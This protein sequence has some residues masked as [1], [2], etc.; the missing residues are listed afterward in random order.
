MFLDWMTMPP[1]TH[2][3]GV[4]YLFL[5][6]LAFLWG[7]SYLFLKIAVE[8]I[9]PITLIAFRAG[10]AALLLTLIVFVRGESFPRDRKT[11]SQLL[12]QAFL[13]GIGAWTVLAWGQQY[14]DSS[15]ASVLNSTSPLFV[16]FITLFVTRHEATNA[17]KLLGAC[18]GICGV[19]LIVG[20][21]ALAGLGQQVVAQLAVLSGAVMYAF[22]SIYGQKFRHLSPL[23]TAA[24]TMSWCAIVLLPCAL[25]LEQPWTLDP[26]SKSLWAALTLSV[27]CTAL[28]LLIYFRLLRTLGSIGTASQSYLRAG[29]GVILGVIVLGE[30]ITLVVACGIVVAIV[31]V[32]LIN[33]PNKTKGAG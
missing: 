10:I 9:P 23:V 31:G 13:N 5:L 3:L 7:S 25:V 15:L 22:A 2:K 27:F 26:S 20:T 24:A 4:E 17:L 8:T 29:I 28:A 12:V 1:T 6:L 14:I 11:Q 32:V 18:L 30:T 19:I 33:L 21:D 16:F